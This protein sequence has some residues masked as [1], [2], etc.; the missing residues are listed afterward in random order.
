[1]TTFFR[2]Q[3][4]TSKNQKQSQA[5]GPPSKE[6]KTKPAGKKNIFKKKKSEKHQPTLQPKNPEKDPEMQPKRRKRT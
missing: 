1:M 3:N 2:N 5:K 4:N 6:I